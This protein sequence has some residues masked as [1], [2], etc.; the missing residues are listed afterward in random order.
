MVYLIKLKSTMHKKIRRFQIRVR[1]QHRA[2]TRAFRRL[3]RH[4]VMIPVATFLALCIIA[5]VGFLLLNGG[6]PKFK[7]ITSYIVIITHDHE[8]QTVPTNERTVG[9][10]LAKLHIT[11]NQGD[12]VEPALSAQINED[13][14]RINIYR[15]LPVEIVDDGQITHTLSAAATPRSIVEQAGITLYPEDGVTEST[16]TNIVNSNSVASQVVINRATPINLNVY[17]TQ[18]VTRTHDA[19]VGALLA[20]KHVVLGKGDSVDP[21]PS[22]PITANMQVFLLHHG[23]TI[24][25]VSQV[26]PAPVQS[27]PDSSLTIGTSA[28]RQAGSAGVELVTYEVQL[29]NGVPVGRTP[30]QTVV[31]QPPVTRIL[32]IGT[33]S[34]GGDLATW[35][36]KL[37]SCESGGNYQ[38]DTGNGYY[39]AY[40]FSAGTWDRLNTGYAYAYEAPPEVQDTAII[41]NTNAS[42]GGIASQNPGCYYKEGLSAYPPGQ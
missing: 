9:L 36:Y 5:F 12:V 37:R 7:P 14:F 22:T 6:K 38:D 10:L 17:G 27:I 2:N 34:L 28:V 29:Q 24:Q 30:I 32:A 26:I 4:P 31:T 23:T 19:T 8:Q 16:P 20:D 35:L 18:T 21:A 11:L 3:R 33:A 1:R 40:Q 41:E 39:G 42:S 13:N 25:T 15:A